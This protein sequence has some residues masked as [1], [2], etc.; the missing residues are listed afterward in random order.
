ML[1]GLDWATPLKKI[2]LAAHGRQFLS[3]GIGA[4]LSAIVWHLAF[5]FGYWFIKLWAGLTTGATFG[6]MVGTIWQL[7]DPGRRSVTSGWFVLTGIGGWGLFACVSLIL[8][9]PMLRAQEVQRSLMR[10]LD[11]AGISEILVSAEGRGE[12]RI[13]DRERIGAFIALARHAESFH[14]D[15]EGTVSRFRVTII[16][17]GDAPLDYQG[18]VPTRHLNDLALQYRAGFSLSEILIRDGRK[19]VEEAAR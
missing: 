6:M 10:S 4:I 2:R 3:V 18:R 17:R 7:R 8:L 11:P 14:P 13:Q 9:A 19:W 1:S 15:H 12:R 16:R 5:P